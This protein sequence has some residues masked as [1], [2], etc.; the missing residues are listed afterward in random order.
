MGNRFDEKSVKTCNL[1]KKNLSNFG[2][3]SR[4]NSNSDFSFFFK[5]PGFLHIFYAKVARASLQIFLDR[6]SR[7]HMVVRT[8]VCLKLGRES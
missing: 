5:F 6:T 3:P 1:Y 8:L 2:I 7:C 4:N